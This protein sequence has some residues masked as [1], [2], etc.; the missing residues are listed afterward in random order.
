MFFDTHAHLNFAAFQKDRD[1]LIQGCLNQNV[2]MINIGTNF[3]TSKKAVEIA[4]NYK[5][6]VFAA[7]GLHPINL[8]TGL[9]K[10]KVDEN[11]L[12]KNEES[13]FE[14]EFDYQRYKK[15]AQKKKVVAIGE[16]GLDYY[17]KPK[18][19]YKKQIFKQ[20]QKEL[21]L[22]QMKLAEELNLPII[23][24]CRMAHEELQDILKETKQKIKGVVHSFVGTLDQLKRYLTMG[25][26]IGFNGII[27]KN[28]QGI[29][30]E[31]LVNNTP[32]NKLLIETDCPY[33]SPPGYRER[34]D[35]FGVRL[36]AKEISRIKNISPEEVADQ[37]FKNAQTL[38]HIKIDN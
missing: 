1:S 38:F 37:T 23:I 29:N 11:E 8:D 34:N 27:F 15:L 22:Q 3:L 31:E 20:K 17:C 14:K 24:H 4:Q 21:F 30:F 18:T 26:Y 36:V 25:F 32:I 10:Q 19:Q 35:P 2:W 28:I 9:I 12:V 16:I 13:P 7:V 6:G 5:E 33:L